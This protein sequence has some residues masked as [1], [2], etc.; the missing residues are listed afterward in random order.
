M[1]IYI[2]LLVLLITV[3][4][5][6]TAF[7]SSWIILQEESPNI[8]LGSAADE[9]KTIKELSEEVKTIDQ[10]QE[11][12]EKEHDD[13]KKEIILSDFFRKD[14]TE[15]EK[16]KLNILVLEYKQTK[17]KLNR[18]LLVQS[19]K[20][21][22]TKYIIHR[23]LETEKEIYKKLLHFIDINKYEE[24]KEFIKKDINLINQKSNLESEELKKEVIIQNKISNLK[25]KIEEHN[26]LLSAKLEQLVNQKIDEKLTELINKEKF[27]KLDKKSQIKL[28]EKLINSIKAKKDILE[29]KENKT[30]LL[31]KKIKLYSIIIDRI[32]LFTENNLIK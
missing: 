3:V 22:D 4:F 7:W 8:E 19:R 13:L 27:K 18:E 2:K 26:D 17:E 15:P 9:D 23:L 14:L 24:Y 31:F 5:S 30:R 21:E 12:T 10:K 11:E 16:D 6:N 25:D 28:F 32:E 1:N 20:L 29:E